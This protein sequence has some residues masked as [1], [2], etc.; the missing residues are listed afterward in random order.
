MC[1]ANAQFSS[2]KQKPGLAEEEAE[3]TIVQKMSFAAAMATR[4]RTDSPKEVKSSP[5]N[6][7]IILV[8]ARRYYHRAIR[9]DRT[10]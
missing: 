2:Q 7:L 3:K 4:G 10:G 5:R 6:L 1:K 9:I 8:C